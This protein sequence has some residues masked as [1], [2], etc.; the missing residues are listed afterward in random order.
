MKVDP[1]NAANALTDSHV[2][3]VQVTSGWT[4]LVNDFGKFDPKTKVDRVMNSRKDDRNGLT[5]EDIGESFM[6]RTEDRPVIQA[7]A[8]RVRNSVLPNGFL[9]GVVALP[10]PTATIGSTAVIEVTP[11][12]ASFPLPPPDINFLIPRTDH[13]VVKSVNMNPPTMTD[14]TL[15]TF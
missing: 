7:N 10:L 9:L 13:A 11:T 8:L 6:R 4:V 5:Y 3:H 2:R 14:R 1:V 12:P 15:R